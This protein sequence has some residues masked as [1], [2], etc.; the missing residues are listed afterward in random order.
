MKHFTLLFVA[1]IF[2]ANTGYTQDLRSI[3]G[4]IKE[5]YERE[6][7]H[8]LQVEYSYFEG[9][10]TTEASYALTMQIAYQG[11]RVYARFDQTEQFGNEDLFLEVDHDSREIYVLSEAPA[12]PPR[13]IEPEQIDQWLAEGKVDLQAI[14]SAE[15]WPGIRFVYPQEAMASVDVFYDQHYKIQRTVL[16]ASVPSPYRIVSDYKDLQPLVREFPYRVTDFIEKQDGAFVPA[17]RF[18]NYHVINKL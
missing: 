14:R 1:W 16:G 13:T 8:L 6:E 9:T 7:Y 5:V 10:K 17:I 18:R 2:I 11:D 15:G 12:Q 3:L 4:R